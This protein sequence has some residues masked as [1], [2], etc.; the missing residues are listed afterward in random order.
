MDEHEK[1]VDAN[2]IDVV[3]VVARAQAENRR[4]QEIEAE[5]YDCCDAE[6]EAQTNRIE[7]YWNLC[8]SILFKIMLDATVILLAYDKLLDVRLQQAVVL[9]STGVICF[10]AGRVFGRKHPLGRG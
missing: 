6:N 10:K 8:V 5:P 7:E 4:N 9:I 3:E 2:D 1:A